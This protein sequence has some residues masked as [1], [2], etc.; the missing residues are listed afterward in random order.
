V[1]GDDARPGSSEARPF[2]DGRPAS[3][4][5]RPFDD[6][7][8]DLVTRTA[9][10]GSPEDRSAYADALRCNRCGFCTSFCPTYLATGDEGLSPRGRNQAFRALLEGR[11]ADPA[12]ASRSF[13]TCLQC[14]ICTSVCFS[15]VPTAK[16]MSAAKGKVLE[17]TGAPAP[18]RWI[19]RG[20]LPRPGVFDPL[21]RLLFLGKRLGVSGLLNRLGVLRRIDPRLAAAESMVE[22]APG[23]FLRARLPPAGADAEVVQFLACGSNYLRPSVGEATAELL[24]T[25]GVK[26]G[27]APNV[28]C[29]LPGTSFGDREAARAMARKNIEAL[30]RHPQAV[31]LVDDSSCAAAVKD[32][33]SLFRDD[34]GAEEADWLRRAR[35]VA[36]RTRDLLE[37]L[38]AA[39]RKPWTADR[40]PW[41]V[42]Y[43]DS[44]KAR[45]GQGLVEQ[46]RRVLKAV[47][48]VEL[49]ELEESDQCCG[50]GGT[51][52]FMQPDL[53]KDVLARKM[54]NVESTETGTVLTSAV[55]CLLQISSG[56]R[57]AGSKMKALHIAEFLAARAKAEK[58]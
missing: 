48:G 28:C 8:P 33:P 38:D 49:R 19:L 54:Q 32:Y 16:L 23:A 41:T 37:W 52:S 30:E 25:A 9:V 24:S 11:L 56:L 36:G 47:P 6:G 51:F 3:S 12:D 31:V 53:S 1:S 4:E 20:L 15:E 17:S 13:D 45:F 2:D 5:A 43:H 42:T 18:L 55:S 34:A 10:L 14:G 46:P 27:A 21:L 22:R 29:G 57:R 35:A 40:G 39:G 7:R 26:A 44:C 50:G 58:P